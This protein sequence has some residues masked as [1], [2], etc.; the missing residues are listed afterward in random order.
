MN[1]EKKI[2]HY[3]ALVVGGGI[4]GGEAALNLANS[5]Y[6]VLLVEKERSL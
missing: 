4:A 3:D 6:R 1:E 2:I 5:G